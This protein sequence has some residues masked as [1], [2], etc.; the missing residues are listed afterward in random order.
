MLLSTKRLILRPWQGSDAKD[1]YEYAKDPK[2][3]PAAGWPVHTSIENSLEI[4]E[5]VFSSPNVFAICMKEDKRAIGCIGIV[6]GEDSNMLIPA[7]EGEIG[8]WLGVPFWGQGLMPEAVRE[9]IRFSFEDLR[10]KKLWCGYFDG[11]QNSKRVQEKC[12]FIYKYTNENKKWSLLNTVVTEHI[13]AITRDEWLGA[14][15]LN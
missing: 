8:F 12:G 14:D 13:S 10:L 15:S 4:I 3:G 1:L 6:R 9:I 7:D 11:N 5:T 2:V